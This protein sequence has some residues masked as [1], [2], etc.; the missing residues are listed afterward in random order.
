M[1]ANTFIDWVANIFTKAHEIGEWLATPIKITNSLA[2]SPLMLIS[3]G[4]LVVFV[5]IAVVKWVIS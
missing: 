4:G 2:L 3:I 5:G 1:D